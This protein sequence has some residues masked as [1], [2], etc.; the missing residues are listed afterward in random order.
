MANEFK[1]GEP[2]WW[3]IEGLRCDGRVLEAKGEFLRVKRMGGA[4]WLV[5]KDS[6]HHAFKKW[7]AWS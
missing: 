5:G 1:V 3:K 6:L 7:P 2:V 4:W